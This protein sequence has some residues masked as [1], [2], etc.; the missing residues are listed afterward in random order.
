MKNHEKIENIKYNYVTYFVSER[1]GFA[2]TKSFIP[3]SPK[4]LVTANIPNTLKEKCKLKRNES[5]L[6]LMF[7][8]AS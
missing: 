2:V 7:V 8:E 1:Y 4:L 6:V 3:W 5:I